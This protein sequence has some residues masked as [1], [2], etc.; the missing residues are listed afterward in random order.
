LNYH[1]PVHVAER[2]LGEHISRKNTERHLALAYYSKFKMLPKVH[3]KPYF[4]GL[5]SLFI[6]EKYQLPVI[7]KATSRNEKF[8]IF[9]HL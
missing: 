9:G 4:V 7:L 2:N 8:T 1:F 6:I 5:Q 3:L